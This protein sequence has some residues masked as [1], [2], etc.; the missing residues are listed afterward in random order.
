MPSDF[1]DYIVKIVGV[2]KPRKDKF[3]RAWCDNCGEDRGYL[4]KPQHRRSKCNKCSQIGRKKSI[5]E[6]LKLSKTMIGNKH[7]TL[8]YRAHIKNRKIN[9]I[10]GRSL[11]DASTYTKVQIV[12]DTQKHI[13]K[14]IRTMINQNVRD[15]N[16]KPTQDVLGYSIEDL[17]KHLEAQFKPGMSWDNYGRGGWH[18]DH[19]KPDSWF[20]Y[21]SIYDENFKKSWSLNNLQPLWESENC[22]KNNRYETTLGDD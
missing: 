1:T 3:Y 13:R 16:R 12:S 9:K 2:N 19:V 22:S 8:E 14:N 15:K 20:N 18:I 17:K 7:A 6:R 21:S 5:E 4:L 10:D 11:R